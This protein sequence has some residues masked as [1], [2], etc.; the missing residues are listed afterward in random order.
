MKSRKWSIHDWAWLINT[1]L[2]V[3]MLHLVKNS[4]ADKPVLILAIFYP[5]LI[6]INFL[7]WIILRKRNNQNSKGYLGTV[8][9]LIAVIPLV[10]LFT[11]YD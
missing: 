2:L 10:L 7:I 8:I 6:F 11:I 4:E 5:A 3:L 9:G 1:F